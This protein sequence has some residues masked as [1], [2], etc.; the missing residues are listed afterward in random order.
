M[1][2]GTEHIAERSTKRKLYIESSQQCFQSCLILQINLTSVKTKDPK[3]MT[4]RHMSAH[5]FLPK[6]NS[7]AKY[8]GTTHHLSNIIKAIHRTARN[9]NFLNKCQ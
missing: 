7:V 9:Y 5:A 6:I 2:T 4:G 1:L 3:T 8:P